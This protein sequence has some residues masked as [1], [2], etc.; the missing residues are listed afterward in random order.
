MSKLSSDEKVEIIF[1]K[2]KS[3]NLAKKYNLCRT[4]P[5]DIKNDAKKIIKDYYDNKK[6]GR[7]AKE[8]NESLNEIAK[9]KKE[10]EL[11]RAQIKLK[12][13]VALLEK[14]LIKEESEL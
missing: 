3:A 4:T 12:D 9:L 1:S 11:L 5:S 7:P 10:N 13:E 6:L 8:L 14:K 2:E